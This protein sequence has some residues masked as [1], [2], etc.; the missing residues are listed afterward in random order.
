VD[1]VHDHL[2][3]DVGARKRNACDAGVAMT[4][5]THR[6]EEMCNCARSLV[7]RRLRLLCRRVG[8]SARDD[9]AAFA[10]VRDQL[11]RARQLR[12]QRH[13]CDAT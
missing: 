2:D 12:C 1:A 9:D 8:V 13:E 7:E 4:E 5:R 6:V 3:D 11:D 10:Q